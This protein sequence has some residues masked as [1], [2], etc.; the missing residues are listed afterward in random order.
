MWM[1]DLW[2]IDPLPVPPAAFGTTAYYRWL[3]QQILA[4]RTR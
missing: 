4:R 3:S 2:E 1:H